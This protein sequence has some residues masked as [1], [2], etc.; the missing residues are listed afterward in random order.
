MPWGSLLPRNAKFQKHTFK[1]LI[2]IHSA[3]KTENN[4]KLS[5]TVNIST[6]F[7]EQGYNH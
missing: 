3:D 5:I 1:T 7:F 4:I 2:Q 6:W